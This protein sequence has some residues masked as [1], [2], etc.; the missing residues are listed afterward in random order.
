MSFSVALS[1]LNAASQNLGVTGNNIAN[2]NTIGFKS[3]RTEFADVYSQTSYGLNE[4]SVGSG[5]RLA[6]VRQS[7]DQGGVDFTN[8]VLD[9]AV[10]GKGFLTFANG[11]QL[12]YS[13]A[14]N[15]DTDRNG[16]VVNAQGNRLQVFPATA[17]GAIDTGRLSDLQLST[18]DNPPRATTRLDA[19]LNLPAGASPPATAVFDPTDT[20]SFNHTTS[21][22]IFDSQGTA[23][24]AALYFVKT[25]NPNEWQTYTAIGGQVAGAPE[26]VTF[27]GGG[28]LV[29]PASGQI[30]LPA[31][32]LGNGADDLQINIGLRDVSQY[33]GGFSVNNTMRQDGYTT[34]RISGL[35]ITPEGIV[36][37]RFTNGQATPLGQIALTQFAN[38]QGLQQIGNTAWA[39]S[40][41]SGT[42][43]R[44]TAGSS[45]F[46]SVQAGAL[47]ASNVDLTAELVN[48]ITAQRTFQANAQMISTT[49][50]IT[51]TIL[52]IR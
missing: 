15:L 31:Q 45:D 35:E 20:S 41:T 11:E 5:V 50:S 40:F 7:F 19:S 47:E 30:T 8:R 14:G 17:T 33:G 16:Y 2:A 39:E 25:A 34:G 6:S 27:D 42:A 49:D 4:R 24:T 46:G 51:Q 38:P 43:Q 12:V 36:Q 13:R 28:R 26:T 32:A 48:M 10:D 52:N 1:G 21:A 3:S 44:G 37:A 23:H 9:V 18:M 22:T 29:S